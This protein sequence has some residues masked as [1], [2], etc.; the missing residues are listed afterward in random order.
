MI[1]FV[2]KNTDIRQR[3]INSKLNFSEPGMKI[4]MIKL[5]VNLKSKW[6]TGW[7]CKR[8]KKIQTFDRKVKEIEDKTETRWNK[9]KIRRER[10]KGTKRQWKK[11]W[12]ENENRHGKQERDIKKSREANEANNKTESRMKS[13]NTWDDDD[14][15][16]VLRGMMHRRKEMIEPTVFGDAIASASI[17]SKERQADRQTDKQTKLKLVGEK[18]LGPKSE[19]LSLGAAVHYTYILI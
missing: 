19:N 6:F 10:G 2:K 17:P 18:V 14:D 16:W 5:G 9:Y 4:N 11:I 12:T 1:K 15:G 3:K 13:A 8:R 7:K